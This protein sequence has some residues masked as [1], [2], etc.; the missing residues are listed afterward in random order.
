[1]KELAIQLQ[2]YKL[3]D[4]NSWRSL[5]FMWSVWLQ[6][7]YGINNQGF[8]C[9]NVF[10]WTF[11]PV[12]VSSRL[13]SFNIFLKHC[14]T[15]PKL[16]LS[17]GD[18][19]YRGHCTTCSVA[20]RSSGSISGILYWPGTMVHFSILDNVPDVFLLSL[21]PNEAAISSG[22]VLL[23]QPQCNKTQANKEFFQ[24]SRKDLSSRNGSIVTNK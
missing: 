13:Q 11:L 4:V 10:Y 18:C 17:W 15:L 24:P 23:L 8:N 1:M 7:N 19:L 5:V 12:L 22:V 2:S 3:Y 14:Y 9:E 6:T 21:E 16:A 20:W